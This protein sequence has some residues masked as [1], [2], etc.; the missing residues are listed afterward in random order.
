MQKDMKFHD[1]ITEFRNKLANL[2][3]VNLTTDDVD[4]FY[5][6]LNSFDFHYSLF[7]Y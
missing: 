2:E 4:K 1:T 5:D 3:D 7:L 6:E